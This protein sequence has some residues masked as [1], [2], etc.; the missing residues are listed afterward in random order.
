MIMAKTD[1]ESAVDE[2]IALLVESGFP[3]TEAGPIEFYANEEY[4]IAI[5]RSMVSDHVV[6]TIRKLD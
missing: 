2:Y 1:H 4:E 6:I 3:Q 5:S